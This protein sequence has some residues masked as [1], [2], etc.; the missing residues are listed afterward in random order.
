MYRLSINQPIKRT[1]S[2]TTT[3]LLDVSNFLTHTLGLTVCWKDLLRAKRSMSE[4]YQHFKI[5]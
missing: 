5:K 2:I 4:Q 3:C 1:A